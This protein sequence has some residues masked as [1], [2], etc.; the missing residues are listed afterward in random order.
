MYCIMYSYILN[1]CSHIIA[2]RFDFWPGMD[3]EFELAFY[4]RVWPLWP[5]NP[6]PI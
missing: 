2:I 5:M 4:I 3:F 6:I 1:L